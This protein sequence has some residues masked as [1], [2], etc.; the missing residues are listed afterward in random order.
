MYSQGGTAKGQ[1]TPQVDMVDTFLGLADMVMDDVHLYDQSTSSGIKGAHGEEGHV[2]GL[3]ETSEFQAGRQKTQATQI[4]AQGTIPQNPNSELEARLSEVDANMPPHL[5]NKIVRIVFDGLQRS[6]EW[7]LSGKSFEQLLELLRSTWVEATGNP[8]EGQFFPKTME[9]T[10]S[11]LSLA[12][13][14]DAMVYYTCLKRD[15]Y[16][17]MTKQSATCPVCGSEA[18]AGIKWLYVGGFCCNLSSVITK[19]LIT[20]LTIALCHLCFRTCN[21]NCAMVSDTLNVQDTSVSVETE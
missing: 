20:Y 16:H 8:N 14:Q 15:H 6:I 2:D 10:I 19:D 5:I 17:N 21:T 13:Y 9:D 4:D 1:E 3:L 12:G 11:I 7:T 18:A